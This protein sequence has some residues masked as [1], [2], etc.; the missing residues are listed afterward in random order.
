MDGAQG[1]K[2][3]TDLPWDIPFLEEEAHVEVCLLV[4]IP[5]A[6]HDHIHTRGEFKPLHDLTIIGETAALSR[7]R[8]MLKEILFQRQWV[9]WRYLWGKKA[10]VNK[11]I[12]LSVDAYKLN[13]RAVK[14]DNSLT[15]TTAN[16]LL[17]C[18]PQLIFS[19]CMGYKHSQQNPYSYEQRI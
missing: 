10:F 3:L 13:Y 18:M 5:G 9:A 2:N 16:G 17:A 11:W 4:L 1:E 19:V 8:T 7:S 14:P 6:W 12:N 15:C